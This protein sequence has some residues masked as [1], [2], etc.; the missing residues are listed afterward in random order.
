MKLTTA[1]H[2]LLP[3]S[4]VAVSGCS[5]Q[6]EME[7]TAGMNRLSSETSAYLLAHADNP[8]NWYP[9]GEEAFAAAEQ[10]GKPIFLSIGYSSCHW[11]HV[12]EQESFEDPEVAALLNENYICIKVDREERPDIDNLYMR[13]TVAVTGGGGWPMTV[14][15][16]PGGKPFF[17]G[18]YIPKNASFGR[19]GMMQLL[20]SIAQSW[21]ADR[22]AMEIQAEQIQSHVM[23]GT[24]LQA[25]AG[26]PSRN[27]G[28]E[29]FLAFC[30]SFD[31]E[32]GGFGISPKFPSPHNLLFLLRYWKTTG[33]IEALEMVTQTLRAIRQGGVYD[34]TGFGVHRYSTDRQ[35]LVPH[36]EKMLYDQALLSMAC[37][38]A[39]QA[40]A[41]SLFS[42][43]ASE[44]YSYIIRDMTSPEG[45]FYSSEDADSE[46]GEGSFYTWTEAELRS[47]LS[48]A[49]SET[50]LE[51]WN[52]ASSGNPEGIPHLTGD[53]ELEMQPVR[54]AL[55]QS[56][57]TRP[58]PARDE[59]ILADWNGLMIASLAEAGTVLGKPV[60]LDAAVKCF[61]FT[62]EYMIADNGRLSHSH[63][64]GRKGADGFL[65]DYA[66]QIWGA[67]N[68]YS[69][70]L[71]YE[72]LQFAVDLQAELDRY[73][74]DSAGGGYYFSA[75][76]ADLRVARLKEAYDGAV[77]SGN[78]VEITNLITLWKLT[79]DSEYLQSA[80]GIQRAFGP[81]V[82]AAPQGYSMMLSGIMY[83][84]NGGTEV[85][86]TGDLSDQAL[87]EMLGVVRSGY[88]PWTTV[89]LAE[90]SRGYPSWIADTHGD[91]PAAGYLC[92]GGTCSLPVENGAALEELMEQQNSARQQ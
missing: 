63:A 44:I 76:Y 68:L 35:W 37:L 70:I 65:D 10:E 19:A 74:A 57:N 60:Y 59:K 1:V 17:A 5:A 47:V 78:S 72:Y 87:V 25:A 29:G 43:T 15:M 54:E 49:Q 84:E 31:R 69:A 58:R 23:N 21:S 12:M 24:Q 61:H 64:G 18:T 16:T 20:P 27:I 46:G 81:Q 88:R 30:S 67:L 48:T 33:D 14:I 4:I 32:F 62:E 26:E 22:D 3:V 92:T 53:P 11:C 50:A 73:F 71:Q 42:N 38:E 45:A 79:G 39:Y 52:L 13:Y 7:R 36:F 28:R 9:W 6:E 51:Y 66:F 77:P 75:D 82:S 90:P 83:A 41:D 56:R 8:V 34:Q 91:S 86:L 85:L 89:M 55:L 80:S 40:T 2:L